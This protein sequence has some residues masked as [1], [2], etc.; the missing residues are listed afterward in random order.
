MT[1]ARSF[2]SKDESVPMSPTRERG[3]KIALMF[4]LVAERLSSFYAEGQWL[5]DAHG[6]GLA[7]EWLARSKRNL[8][9]TERR[10]LSSLSD[11]LAREVAGSVSRD[12]GL[13]LSHELTEALDPNYQSEIALSIVEECE[14][15]LSAA[16]LG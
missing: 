8:P 11:D 9:L 16:E 12:A 13:Y 4:A 5:S 7:R 3:V 2:A 15:R 10:V 6:V 1:S 14:R